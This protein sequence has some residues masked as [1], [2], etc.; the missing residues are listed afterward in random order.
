MLFCQQYVNSQNNWMIFIW[1]LF[2][3]LGNMQLSYADA[4][5]HEESQTG[6]DDGGHAHTKWVKPPIGY[7]HKSN[8]DWNDQQSALR[9]G[10]LYL[11][12][13]ASCHGVTG[14]GSGPVANALE[15]EPADL[16]NHFHRGPG[17][18]D[19]YLFWRVSEGG[20]VE[21]FKSQG[22]A[23]PPFKLMLD[24]QQRWD[25]LTYIHQLFHNAGWDSKEANHGHDSDS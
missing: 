11:D 4:G 3:V 21:P 17:L 22:S 12:N 6:H 18:G 19:G 7:I 8:P 14:K 13:C 2:L 15:H 25:V 20:Q 16:T 10:K 9:G 5:G 24:E 1:L 23:M